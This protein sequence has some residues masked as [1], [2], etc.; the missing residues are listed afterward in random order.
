MSLLSW[1]CL[2]PPKKAGGDSAQEPAGELTKKW[3]PVID[4]DSCIGC[5]RCVTACEHGC[6]EMIWSFANLTNPH[7]CTGEGHCT[8]V[9]PQQ[10]IHMEWVAIEPNETVLPIN[11]LPVNKVPVNKDCKAA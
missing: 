8:E 7:S 10:I 5:E 3:A 9:C 11:A 1:M 2:V 4:R 6:L